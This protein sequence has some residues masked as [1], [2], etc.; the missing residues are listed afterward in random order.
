MVTVRIAAS[1]GRSNCV[2]VSSYGKPVDSTLEGIGVKTPVQ[3]THYQFSWKH[4][5]YSIAIDKENGIL[6]M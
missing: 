5:S 3:G 2:L 4:K 1:I 6:P